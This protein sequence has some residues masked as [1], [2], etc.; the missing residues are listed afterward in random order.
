MT[1]YE[2][3]A[4]LKHKMTRYSPDGF[5]IIEECTECPVRFLHDPL[6]GY[7]VMM[8]PQAR[9]RR[10]KKNPMPPAASTIEEI[11]EMYHPRATGYFVE[12]SGLVGFRTAKTV[13]T[14]PYPG[15]PRSV[16]SRVQ[17]IVWY[18]YDADSGCYVRVGTSRSAGNWAQYYRFATRRRR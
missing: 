7:P 9:F 3:H 6:V 8:R 10:G 17:T 15:S 4:K 5:V 14:R 11:I 1:P 2:R 13:R 16:V 18:G 12:P